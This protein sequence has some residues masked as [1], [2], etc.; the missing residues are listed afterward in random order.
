[1]DTECNFVDDTIVTIVDVPD[2][3]VMDVTVSKQPDDLLLSVAGD[4]IG[5][6]DVTIQDGAAHDFALP[7]SS[8]NYF[9]PLFKPYQ[10]N[11]CTVPL[12]SINKCTMSD[13]VFVKN[14]CVAGICTCKHVIGGR[15]AQLLPCRIAPLLFDPNLA[16]ADAD[17]TFLWEGFLN[18]FK[19]VDQDC[20]TSY[21]CPNYDSILSPEFRGEMSD[22]IRS[23]LESDKVSRALAVPQC[24]HALGAVTKSNGKLRPITDCSRP[25][26]GCINNF[27]SST[28]RPFSY[29][30]VDSAVDLLSEG[31]FMAVVDISAAYRSVNVH[32]EHTKFQGFI[33]NLEGSDEMYI[34]NR[35]CFGLRCAPNIFSSISDFVV[36]ISHLWGVQNVVNYLDD[37]LI[38]ADTYEDCLRQRDI[39][40]GAIEHIGF[41]VASHKVTIPSTTCVF[42]GITLDSITM[43]VSLPLPKVE[44]L[45]SA[46]TTA[47]DKAWVTKKDLERIGG[48]MSFCAYVVRGARTFS[49]RLFDL[50]AA[51]SR[52]AKVKLDEQTLLD[53][54]WWLRFLDVFNGRAI[55]IRSLH[56]VPI[57]SDSS[58]KG[59]GA[60]AGKDWFFGTWC[61]QLDFDPGCGHCELPPLLQRVP[62]NINV[63]ELWPIVVGVRR[64]GHHYKNSRIHLVTDNMQVLAMINTGRSSNATCMSWLRELFWACF[65]GNFDLH[66]TYIK[67]SDNVLADQLSR[68]CYPGT[69]I[70]CL[71]YLTKNNFCCH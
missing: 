17:R 20:D 29:N 68:L 15:A 43:E 12:F 46:I 14:D 65:L 32:S 71:E 44:K 28:Y 55:M 51:S 52:R 18:G 53:F 56:S 67:S 63:Y 7:A 4:V 25:E 50:C 24:V 38:I 49:R 1:M 19:I 60:W 3:V 39:V 64:W 11:D 62:K 36:A 13:N 5:F 54:N 2:P 33:W 70:K 66:A 42:L 34:D 40:I 59:F 35:L 48:L 37:F 8:D 47:S 23:E 30:S 6:D 57:T 26:E 16:I 31:C 21:M 58:N 61:D 45:K 41:H 69:P 10:V 27:M 9:Q 22:L